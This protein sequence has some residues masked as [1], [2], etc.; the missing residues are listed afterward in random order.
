M[1]SEARLSRASLLLGPTEL[2]ASGKGTVNW[3]VTVR[4]LCYTLSL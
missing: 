2:I 3:R 4:C 1:E